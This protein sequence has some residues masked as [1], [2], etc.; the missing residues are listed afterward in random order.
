MTLQYKEYKIADTTYC[1]TSQGKGETLVLLHGFTGSSKTWEPFIGT[2]EKQYHLVTVDLPGHGKTTGNATL[3]MEDVCYHLQQL[4]DYLNIEK[5]H[6]IGYSMGGRTA[7][8]FAIWYPKYIASF[9]LESAS[10]GL[11][12][13][14]ERKARMEH[15]QQLATR[16]LQDGV[17]RFVDFWEEIPLFATQKA[18]TLSARESLRAERL[19]Q[20][21]EG[22]AAS[23]T[24]IGTGHQPSWWDKLESIT[25]PVCLIVGDK[26][27]KFVQINEQMERRLPNATCHL[28]RN[29]GHAVHMEHPVAFQQIVQHFIEQNINNK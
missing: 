4:F 29:V 22:L 13:E 1:Y 17:E 19:Q 25:L 2:W 16:I 8:S 28:V 5:C 26:D 20:T 9:V 3:S 10:A 15:D 7:L 14:E 21:A 23:L 11:R 24:S 18:M 12:T 6:L 27:E